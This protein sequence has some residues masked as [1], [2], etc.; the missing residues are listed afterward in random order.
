MKTEYAKGYV[1]PLKLSKEDQKTLARIMEKLGCTKAEAVRDAIG[2]YGEYLEGLEVVNLRDLSEEEAKKE[3]Q[4]YLKNK[5]RVRADEIGD[6]LQL[7]LSLVNKVL[8]ALWQE[9]EVEPV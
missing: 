3:I 5:D 2:Y 8:L 9:G 7:N 1:Y 4:A 6:A